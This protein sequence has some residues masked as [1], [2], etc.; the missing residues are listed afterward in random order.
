MFNFSPTLLKCC[1]QLMSIDGL[2]DQLFFFTTSKRVATQEGPQVGRK[3]THA[4]R[5]SIIS[6][7][8]TLG[9]WVRDKVCQYGPQIVV[10]YVA[11]LQ[12]ACLCK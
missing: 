10:I 5:G 2:T 7:D 3:P 9:A 12:I 11:T 6:R 8:Q 1:F 4:G